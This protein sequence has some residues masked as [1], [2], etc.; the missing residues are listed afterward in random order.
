MTDAKVSNTSE[1][2]V[3]YCYRVQGVPETYRA[4][5][6]SSETREWQ[7]AM[8]EEIQALEDNNT[9]TLVPRVDGRSPI[10]GRWVYA[11][12][13]DQDNNVRYK[14]RYVAKGYSQVEHVDYDE[15]FSPTARISSVRMLA[16]LAVQQDLVVHQMDVKSAYLNAEIDCE[17][18]MKQP[19]GYVKLDNNNEP[20]V[21]RLNKSLYGLKQSGRNW[22]IML[23]SFLLDIGFKQSLAD[24]CVYIKYED[25]VKTIII[26]WVDDLIIAAS[27]DN[28]LNDV[29]SSLSEKFKMKDLGKLSWFLGFQFDFID[30]DIIMSQR[31]YVGKMLSKYNMNDCKTKSL[32]CDIS[33]NSI[34]ANDL[35]EECDTNL[36]QSIVGSLIYVMTGT[37][38]DISFIVNKLSQY[39]AKPTKTLLGLA[40]HVLRYLKGT[41][42]YNLIF[43]KSSESLNLIGFCDSDWGSSDDRRSIT[44]YC[45]KLCSDGALISWNSKKQKVVALSSCEAEYTALSAAVQEANFLRQLF[46]D[47]RDC[48]PE[49]VL[50]FADNQGAISLAKNPVHHQRSK[51][52]DIKYHYI[53][54]EV[55]N[56]KIDLQYVQSADN[57]ADIFTKP[58]SKV[59][60]NK[61]SKIK[62][63]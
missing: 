63:F 43:S 61:F 32:P 3:D 25:N 50:I 45:F 9:Y 8:D 39:M 57:V 37:R 62:G 60:F 28:T 17:I 10:G 38:P 6:S 12:K 58:I 40:K 49:K 13:Q 59:R 55:Q 4:A 36:Y 26:V 21:C 34:I 14:A 53:R 46:A 11:L 56:N 52:I 27:D 31:N 42:D 30:S 7:K 54:S 35:K 44:G 23:H 19:Q 20:L 2:Y 15:I 29:K 51:H 48:F 5:M 18:F 33:V 47:M 16:Q 24:N 22:N 41:L 1:L